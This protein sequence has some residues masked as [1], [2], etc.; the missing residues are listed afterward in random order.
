GKV[1]GVVSAS[2]LVRLAAEEVEVPDG[3]ERAERSFPPE[4]LEE[5]GAEASWYSFFAD[6]APELYAGLEG[7]VESVFE[8]A[9]VA[10]IMTRAIFS[11]RPQATVQE[12]ARFL[13]RA[14]CCRALVMD[15]GR[16]AG[17]GTGQD[18]LRVVSDG[19]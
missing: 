1:L 17:V 9:T 8:E 12:L 16:L 6:E 10:D 2:D 14:G 13:L 7:I 15:A 3:L 19:A 5:E 4:E 11:V 18:V